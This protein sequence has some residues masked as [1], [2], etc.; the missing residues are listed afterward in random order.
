MTNLNSGRIAG[1]HHQKIHSAHATNKRI[2]GNA[3]YELVPIKGKTAIAKEPVL[4][5]RERSLKASTFVKALK[6]LLCITYRFT[7]EN[8]SYYSCA[9]RHVLNWVSGDPPNMV[10]AYS[11]I[12]ISSGPRFNTQRAVARPVGDTVLFM[13]E[14]DLM[15]KDYAT[16]RTIMVVYCK[17]LNKCIYTAMGPPRSVCKAKLEVAAFRGQAVHTWLSFITADGIQ[18]SD[19]IY[20]GKLIIDR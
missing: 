11:K 10:I 17:A 3:S 6:P 19:S 13:W 5:Q 12:L 1:Q 16:D 4:L 18:V 9:M 14:N 15:P 7:C 8:L 2:I 20:T